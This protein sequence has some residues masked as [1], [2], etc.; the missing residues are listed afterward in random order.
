[1]HKGIFITGTDTGVGKTF[2]AVGLINALKEK[3]FNVCPMKPVETGCRT[4]KGKLIPEDTMSL[5]KASGIKE[6]IDVINPYRFKHP[7]APSVAAELERKSIKK[8]KIFSA[9]NYLSKKYD[10]TIVEG[11]GGIMAPLYKKYLFLDFIKDLKLPVIIISRPG[12]GTINH[13]LLTIS[14][15]K[16]RGVNILGVVINYAAKTKTGIA[17]KT[18]PE[19]I[20]RLGGV[21]VIGIVLYSKNQKIVKKT[22][23]GIR[24]K[25]LKE[26]K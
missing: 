13:T 15:A 21:P 17:E 3:G 6:A 10:I 9:Y 22:F 18:N 16:G 24:E 23:L 12:L 20:K 7:L 11:A 25:I 2:V 4:K 14:A 8:E 26:L 5:I 1:M 19:I